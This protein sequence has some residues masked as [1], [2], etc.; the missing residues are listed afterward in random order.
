MCSGVLG[1][2]VL[3]ERRSFPERPLGTLGFERAEAESA[4]KT[5]L[6]G[7][8]SPSP[9]WRERERAQPQSWSLSP[10]IHVTLTSAFWPA[11]SALAS[12][13]R[14]TCKLANTTGRFSRILSL[15]PPHRLPGGSFVTR[16]SVPP[17]CSVNF[18]SSRK[19]PQSAAVPLK[20]L[21]PP[22]WRKISAPSRCCLR[23]F[24][25]STRAGAVLPSLTLLRGGNS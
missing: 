11:A 1:D 6:Q 25:P 12:G 2:N 4:P 23:C 21:F 10:E 13:K 18:L 14:K 15:T 22:K 19:Q 16:A 24:L 20:L 9:S 7:R 8:T 5:V 3:P 17:S